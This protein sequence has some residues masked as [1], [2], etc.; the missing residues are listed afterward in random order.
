[1]LIAVLDGICSLLSDDDAFRAKLG[2]LNQVLR[3]SIRP[4]PLSEMGKEINDY[5]VRK[6]LEEDFRQ[7]ERGELKQ[8][9]V[10]LTQ[11]LKEMHVS[12][13]GFGG[14]MNTLIVEIQKT[15]SLTEILSIKEKLIDDLHK[16]R[17]QSLAMK[18][19]LDSY[20]EMTASLSQ[21]LEQSQAKA[22]VD[23]LTNVLNRSA[24]DLSV[25]QLI[26]EFARYKEHGA[27]LMVVDI[28]NFKRFNDNYGHKAGD[29]VLASVASCIRE[30]IRS[31]DA[32]FRYGGEEF[33]V[34]MIKTP[35]VN[36]EKLAEKIRERV[37][38]DYFI[39]KD[40][41]LKVTVSI[42][43][44]CL[45]DGDTEQTLF[46]RADKAMYN[47]KNKGRNRVTRFD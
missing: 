1:L 25:G 34:L 7:A 35:P 46:E 27:A 17:D 47:S 24:Y 2:N 44:T 5:F 36:A 11:V 19:E 33:V 18:K 32:V 16:M 42:G 43:L 22:L 3:N 37:E 38:K 30:T 12:S 4:K 31:S 8:L 26:R 28:D 40:V 20:R 14:E 15:D 45:K 6:K 29:A 23:P 9:V 41:K 39:D 10:D 13:D 21:R